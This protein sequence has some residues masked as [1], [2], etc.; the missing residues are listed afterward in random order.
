V[1][2]W[3]LPSLWNANIFLHALLTEWYKDFEQI[4]LIGSY[5]SSWDVF[6]DETDDSKL[7][8]WMALKEECEPKEKTPA[9]GIS[10]EILS[11]N[12]VLVSVRAGEN[13]HQFVQKCLLP[14]EYLYRCLQAT[15]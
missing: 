8:L 5:T 2:P 6:I 9:K 13:W 10:E 15:R 4:M 11:D 1:P 7:D 12:E 14:L 3:Q